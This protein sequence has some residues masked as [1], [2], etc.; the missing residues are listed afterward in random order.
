MEF[1]HVHI[2]KP[3]IQKQGNLSIGEPGDKY[4]KEADA[5]ASQVMRMPSQTP[6]IM[7]KPESENVSIIHRKCADCDEEEPLQRKGETSVPE[8]QPDFEKKLK[9]SKGSGQP[10]SRDTRHFM[11]TRMNTDFSKVKVHTSGSSAKMNRDI[12][13]KAFTHGND[14]YFN[15]G[16]YRPES[17]DGKQLLAHELT[18]VVQQNGNKV[19]A[20]DKEETVQRY[21]DASGNKGPA[22]GNSYRI[23]DDLSAA[24]KVG[25]PNHDF[26]AK[27]GKAAIANTQLKSVGSGIE[28]EEKSTSF[29]VSH[30]SKKDTLKKILPKNTQN[31]TSGDDMKI[32]DDCGKSNAVVVGSSRRTALHHDAMTGTNA[33]S[34]ATTPSLMKAEIIKKLLNKWLTMASTAAETKTKIRNTIASADAKQLEINAA[35]AAYAAATTDAEKETKAEIYW[36]K[37][38]QYGNIMMSFYN[39]RTEAKR[40][41]I[42]EYLKINIYASPNVGQGYTMSSGGTNYP[43]KKTWNFHWGGVV[44]KSS[45]QKDTITLENYAVDGDVENKKWDFAMY[46]NATKKGQT[47]HEQH[48]DTKQHGDKPTT[49]TIE[50]K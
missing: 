7:S 39:T 22:I 44:M 18:H 26:Y 45:D 6:A 33:K 27:A 37:V 42:D 46:G 23:S 29:D 3:L 25:Y 10:L 43:G 30:E 13:A 21:L 32:S 28:L 1:Q 12:S 35:M 16:N 50:K 17:N 2:K 15:Q 20:K 48:R 24:V 4:E 34:V 40:K 14:I 36:S 38:D 9:S 5:V 41:E 19:R 11:E 8:I 47:F 49:M 31:A